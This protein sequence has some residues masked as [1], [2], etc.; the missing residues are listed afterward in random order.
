MAGLRLLSLT[1]DSPFL[2]RRAANNLAY[3]LTIDGDD[4][5]LSLR[6]ACSASARPSSLSSQLPIHFTTRNQS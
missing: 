3:K 1:D 6:R 5:G 2:R 4:R